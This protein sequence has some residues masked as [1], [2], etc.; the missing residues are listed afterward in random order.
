MKQVTINLYSFAELD[1]TAANI[2]ISNHQDF[3]NTLEPLEG[4][5]KE[6]T[7][8]EYAR[9]NIKINEYLFFQDGTLAHCTTYTG[10]HGKSGKT[11]F[12]FHGSTIELK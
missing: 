7:S 8:R 1:K 6:P 5:D 4:E 2:A 11:E 3:L 9:E 12:H 10:K